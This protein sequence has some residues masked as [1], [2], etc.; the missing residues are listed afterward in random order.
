MDRG[1]TSHNRL[2]LAYMQRAQGTA[3]TALFNKVNVL[4]RVQTFRGIKNRGNIHYPK[5]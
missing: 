4:W 3:R 5:R 1:L 2:D